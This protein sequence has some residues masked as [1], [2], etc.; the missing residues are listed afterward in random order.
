MYH[1]QTLLVLG[2]AICPVANCGEV[3]YDAHI[4]NDI[5]FAG[6]IDYLKELRHEESDSNTA[7]FYLKDWHFVRC[8]YISF[9]SVVLILLNCVAHFWYI[10]LPVLVQSYARN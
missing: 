2:G 5:K 10:F 1:F 7:C 3:K 6:F 4:K 8:V 9:I